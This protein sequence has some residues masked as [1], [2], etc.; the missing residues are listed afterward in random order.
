MIGPA[1]MVHG[2]SPHSWSCRPRSW[3]RCCSSGRFPR[4]LGSP[5][6]TTRTSASR[7]AWTRRRTVPLWFANFGDNS[8]GRIDPTTPVVTSFTDVNINGPRSVS[9]APDGVVW[10]TSTENG[11]LGK[12]DG[13]V[14]TTY[15]AMEQ[16]DDV[17][18]AADG[19]IWFNGFPSVGN[20]RIG[21]FEPGTEDL[22]TYPS[23][24]LSS[25]A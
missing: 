20:Q 23:A 22:Y 24:G 1:G 5:P 6:S 21:R 4:R 14:V 10:F 19:D 13:G 7:S 17:E 16:I 18:V 12:I 8:I 3:E 11:R 15:P 2:G 25:C 9:V